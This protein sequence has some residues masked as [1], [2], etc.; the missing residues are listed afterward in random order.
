MF[1]E[2]SQGHGLP[3]DPFKA[4]VAPRPIGWIS[5]VDKEGRAN[6]AP[7]SF[8]NAICS[9]PPMVMFSSEGYKDSVRNISETG[10]FICNIVSDMQAKQMNISSAA[11]SSETNE[12]ELAGLEAEEGQV[13]PVP[14]VVN[15]V[16]ALEC[17]VVKTEQL[18]DRNENPTH[19]FI[20]IGEVVG[21]H[22][23]DRFIQNGLVDTAAMRLLARCGYMDYA[24]VESVFQIG[25]P[26]L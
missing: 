12:F 26:S 1:Y 14:R 8:F 2:V 11:V 21:V 7:Y 3:H 13:V 18:S 23:D 17:V 25:R 24:C 5:S 6:L 4:L 16:A 9:N 15:A 22:I 20:T 19:S 10:Y